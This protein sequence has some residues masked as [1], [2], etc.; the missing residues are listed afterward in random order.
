MGKEFS[1]VYHSH[2]LDYAYSCWKGVPHVRIPLLLQENTCKK[3]CR[4]TSCSK[5]AMNSNASS[6]EW[7]SKICR[8]TSY[9]LYIQ[10]CNYPSIS[11]IQSVQSISKALAAWKNYIALSLFTPQ[12]SPRRDN[13]GVRPPADLIATLLRPTALHTTKPHKV[14]RSLGLTQG[15][16]P[17]P[18]VDL[19]TPRLPKLVVLG[20]SCLVKGRPAHHPCTK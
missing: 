5:V 11:G 7:S 12:N 10:L 19:A 1:S 18:L 17:P 16:S 14:P 8:L 20:E 13:I 9:K 4:W 2:W 15:D 6:W 3:T